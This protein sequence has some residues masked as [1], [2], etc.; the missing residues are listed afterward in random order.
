MKTKKVTKYTCES[1]GLSFYDKEEVK[2]HEEKCK[3]RVKAKRIMITL[4]DIDLTYPF[5]FLIST[6]NMVQEHELYKIWTAGPE[7]DDGELAC[8]KKWY[9]YIREKDSVEEAVKTMLAKINTELSELKNSLEDAAEKFT[10]AN[11]Q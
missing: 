6:F 2:K 9:M 8:I 3:T 4:L 7:C 1:C 11:K 10:A 5:D